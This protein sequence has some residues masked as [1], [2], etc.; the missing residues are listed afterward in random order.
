M[1]HDAPLAGRTFDDCFSWD[2][3]DRTV[4]L[5]APDGRAVELS[6]DKQFRFLQLFTADHQFS[7]PYPYSA[8]GTGRALAVEPMTAPAYA[9][10]TGE[11][12]TWLQPS[13]E[14]EYTLVIRWRGQETAV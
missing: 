5:I 12:L 7:D 13:E 1:L 3:V 4:R 9:L 2:S 6:A 11:A 14:V 10:N 8:S